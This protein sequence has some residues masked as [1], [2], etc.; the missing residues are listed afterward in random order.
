M[1]RVGKKRDSIGRKPIREWSV[2]LLRYRGEFLG[3]VKAA[4][5]D[6]A[7]TEAAKLFG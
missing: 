6:A 3:Y 4:S 7:E 2:T 5:H 1:K